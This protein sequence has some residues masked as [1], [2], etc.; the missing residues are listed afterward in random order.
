LFFSSGGRSHDLELKLQ[1]GPRLAGSLLPDLVQDLDAGHADA[2]LRLWGLDRARLQGHRHR[3]PR[4]RHSADLSRR[5][6]F[7]RKILK[8]ENVFS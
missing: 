4:G 2:P 3:L 8:N 7:D 1:A 6:S 5:H